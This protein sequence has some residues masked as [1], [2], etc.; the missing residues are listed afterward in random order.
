MRRLA[1]AFLFRYFHGQEQVVRSPAD[2]KS[3]VAALFKFG[4]RSL[5]IIHGAHLQFETALAD[6]EDDIAP[7]KAGPPRRASGGHVRYENAIHRV[8]QAPAPGDVGSDVAQTEAVKGGWAGRR[9]RRGGLA[10]PR[11][12][13][14][15]FD[16][17]G[18][19]FAHSLDF[20]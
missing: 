8:F 20:H 11:G 17:E 3:G 5:E 14:P 7:S 13:F 10:E 4:Q 6:L 9:P 12:L 16:P 18:D 19:R 2:E 15:Q 1:D